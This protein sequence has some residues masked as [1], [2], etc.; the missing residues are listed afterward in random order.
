MKKLP[1]FFNNI[2][3]I[4][5]AGIVL[6]NSHAGLIHTGLLIQLHYIKINNRQH[7]QMMLP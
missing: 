4:A 5:D 6:S 3:G 2:T 1:S 7:K